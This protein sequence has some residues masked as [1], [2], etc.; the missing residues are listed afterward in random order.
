M[1]D[2]RVE[3]KYGKFVKNDFCVRKSL[4][5]QIDDDSGI[6]RSPFRGIFRM[7]LLLGLVYALNSV[8]KHNKRTNN[9]WH[10]ID[11]LT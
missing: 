6:S 4:L 5:D 9:W 11:V 1:K 3:G 2:L 10:D 8:V 7:A